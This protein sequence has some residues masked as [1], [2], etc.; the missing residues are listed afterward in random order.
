MI[1]RLREERALVVISNINRDL[2]EKSVQMSYVFKIIFVFGWEIT[3]D[4]NA[5]FLNL[6]FHKIF[7][8]QSLHKKNTK[9]PLMLL[10]KKWK[11]R[12]NKHTMTE[13]DS[14][15]GRPSSLT[16]TVSSTESNWRVVKFFA[17][18]IFPFVSFISKK[19]YLS[20]VLLLVVLNS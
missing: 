18:D 15:W 8:H 20:S 7:Y 14:G 1:L 13:V 17:I 10:K 5:C 11:E 12:K 2:S 3:T 16:M 4:S 9:C 19:L 6:D